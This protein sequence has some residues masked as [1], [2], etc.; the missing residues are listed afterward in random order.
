[1]KRGF[2]LALLL[3]AALYVVAEATRERPKSDGVVRLRWATDANPARTRQTALFAQKI[4]GLAVTVDP[5]LGNDQ[6]K[7]IVQCATGTGPD[8]IDLYDEQQMSSLI[9]AGVLVDL[10]PYAKTMG[11]GPDRTFPAVQGALGRGGRQYR[12]PCNVWANC[13]VYNKAVFDDH[14]VPYPKPGWTWDEFVATAKRIRDTPSKS[15]QTHL[16]IANWLNLWFYQDSLIGRGGRFFTPDGLVSLADSPESIAAM[17]FYHDLMHVHKVVPTPAD[18]A[19]MSSQGGWGSQGINWFSSGKAAMIVIGRWYIV[20]VP[21]YPNLKGKLGAVVLPRVPGRPSSGVTGTRAA[22]INVKSPRRAEAL[23]FLQYLADPDYGRLIVQDGDALPPNPNLARS[24]Q[25]LANEIIPD[26]AFHQP[27]VDAMK[28]ARPADVSAFIDSGLAA[29]W[30]QER[31]E[32]V[33]NRLLTP[34]AAMRSLAAEINAQIRLNLERRPD[35]Q[36]RYEQVTGRRYTPDW[37]RN[38]QAQR[39][40]GF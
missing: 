11:F 25:D 33:E 6:T 38:Y 40:A 16:P 5:G 26:P 7:L 14:G 8:I 10:T 31:I 34:E 30:L 29:R 4:P 1:M 36:R 15:G 9:E 28:T 17:R 27:F 18:A 13:V 22:G 3:F 2:L 35:L 21:N 12:F 37:W 39:W 23:R 24:G 32:K 19:A 20:Q